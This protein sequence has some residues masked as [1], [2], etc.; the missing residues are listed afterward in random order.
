[1]RTV[2]RAGELEPVRVT[3]FPAHDRQRCAHCA[4]TLLLVPPGA[5]GWPTGAF[6]EYLGNGWRVLSASETKA[7]CQRRMDA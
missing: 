3:G 2:H 6:V 5:F 1:M 7:T 4:E